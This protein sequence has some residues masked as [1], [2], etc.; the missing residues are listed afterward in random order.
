[1]FCF[2]GLG[3][4]VLTPLIETMLKRYD[5]KFTMIL[6]SVIILEIA[7]LGSIMKPLNSQE[8]LDA[9]RK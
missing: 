9:E 8:V 2:Q 5:W 6:C 1:L 3:S 4:F 7:V